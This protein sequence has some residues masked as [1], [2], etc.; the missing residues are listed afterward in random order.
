MGRRDRSAVDE[1]AL[2]QEW[3]AILAAEGLPERLSEKQSREPREVAKRERR[4]R[5][6]QNRESRV[7]EATWA[8]LMNSPDPARQPES[9][10]EALLETVPGEDTLESKEGSYALRIA[11]MEDVISYLGEEQG[12]LF[13]R[14]Y[15]TKTTAKELAEKKGISLSAMER[16]LARARDKVEQLM[17]DNPVLLGKYADHLR[18]EHGH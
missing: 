5:R 2:V 14:H 10:L 15:M 13:I 18:E 4:P 7:A 3:E 17:E 6:A 16:R 1:E 9:A 8:R 11:L 12:D